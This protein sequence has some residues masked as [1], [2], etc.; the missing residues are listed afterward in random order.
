[1]HTSFIVS[2]LAERIF[3]DEDGSVSACVPGAG[4]WPALRIFAAIS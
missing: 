2:V 3:I 4:S 1:M